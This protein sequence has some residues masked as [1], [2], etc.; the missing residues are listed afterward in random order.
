MAASFSASLTL[1]ASPVPTMGSIMGGM[2]GPAAE[3]YMPPRAAGG[4]GS[5]S[6]TTVTLRKGRVGS[7]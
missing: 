7:L 5:G 1:A 3:L 2:A 4:G 6:A